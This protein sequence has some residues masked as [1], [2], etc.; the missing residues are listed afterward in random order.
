MTE[1]G[2][3][4]AMGAGTGDVLGLVL[5]QGLKLAGV[6]VLAGAIGAL[7]LS[8]LIQSLLFGVS[9]FD[10]LTFC[11]MALLLGAVTVAACIV[12]AQRATKVDPLIALR[13]E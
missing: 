13:Y 11:A 4:M 12:P 1:F 2:I 3:R 9:S 6:G 5:T 10:P 8:R 7:A